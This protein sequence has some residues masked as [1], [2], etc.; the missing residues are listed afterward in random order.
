MR[1]VFETT[2]SALPPATAGVFPVFMYDL[3]R[4][5]G[6]RQVGNRVL[7]DVRRLGHQISIQAF[8]FQTIALA[9]TAAD[10]FVSRELAP[11]GWTRSMDL[12]VRLADPG[13][14]HAASGA[15]REALTFL[16]GDDWTLDLRGGGPLPPSPQ[17]RGDTVDLDAESLVCLAS[18]GLDSTIGVID[19]LQAGEH[20]LLVSHAYANDKQRQEIVVNNLPQSVSRWAALVNPARNAEGRNFKRDTTM[21]GRSLNFLAFAAVAASALGAKGVPAP[22]RLIVPENGFI[23]LNPA[24]TIRRLGSLSTRTTHPRFLG[25]IQELFNAVGIAVTIQNP[26]ALRTKGEMMAACADPALLSRLAADT[27]SCGKWKRHRTQCGVCLPCLIR[28]ASFHSAGLADGTTYVF[29]NAADALALEARRD[30][31]LSMMR[32]TDMI[33]TPELARRVCLSGPLPASGSGRE[34]LVAVAERG[35]TEVR[36]YLRAVGIL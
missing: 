14:W 11:D 31:V 25:L 3:D 9:A 21:R 28:R 12:S 20:P 34:E 8:D 4:H 24:L 27:V 30:D 23:A 36:D 19:L 13:P 22:V 33:G 1:L 6:H 5:D 32:A 18:G 29:P 10:T 35:L 16:T 15:L 2:S 17:T 7:S 26:Y